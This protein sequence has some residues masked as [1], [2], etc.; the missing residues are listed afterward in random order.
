MKTFLL[1]MLPH[2]SLCMVLFSGCGN[3]TASTKTDPRPAVYTAFADTLPQRQIMGH[4]F[5]L[6]GD[7]NGDGKPDTMGE[8]YFDGI[9]NRETYKFKEG[10]EYDALVERTIHD[11]C[12]VFLTCSG[13]IPDFRPEIRVSQ[14]FGLSHLKNEGDLNG[15]GTDEVS[16]VIDWADFSNSNT[17]HIITFR[18]GKWE[19]LY[20][21]PIWDWQLP[22]VPGAENEYG[23]FGTEG[24]SLDTEREADEPA[25]DLEPLVR[26]LKG[27]KIKVLYK[28]DEAELDS[29][30]VQLK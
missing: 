2:V 8:H 14:L 17:Y 11:K 10:L 6:T 15:D 21:F 25:G 12:Y 13:N 27:N 23:L 19:E 3:K 5:T 20:S 28:N 1:H 22:P 16:Y 26:K 18:K 29:M 30:V 24:K 7:F 9:E 4:R